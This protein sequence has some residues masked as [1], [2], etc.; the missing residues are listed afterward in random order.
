MAD[1]VAVRAGPARGR[2]AAGRAAW[3]RCPPIPSTCSRCWRR[4]ATCRLTHR[5]SPTRRADSPAERPRL[6]EGP[7][8]QVLAG[9]VGQPPALDR[10]ARCSHFGRPCRWAALRLD[11]RMESWLPADTIRRAGL[12]PR[13]GQ[14]PPRADAGARRVARAAGPGWSTP[15]HGTMPRACLR[16]SRGCW[17]GW[18]RPPGDPERAMLGLRGFD[19]MTAVWRGRAVAGRRAAGSGS[20]SAPSPAAPPGADDGAGPGGRDPAPLR[21]DPRFPRRLHA[22]LRRRRPAQED[23]RARTDGNPEARAH[24][25]DLHEPRAEGVRVRRR[26]ALLLRARPTSRSTWPRSRPATRRRRRRCSWPAR[27]TSRATS[28][29]RRPRPA[30][31]PAGSAAIKLT[32]VKPEREYETLV[33]VVDRATP[34]MADARDRRPPGRHVDVCLHQP[35]RER[36]ASRIASSSSRFP[37]ASM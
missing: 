32:P 29:R 16:R 12:R 8:Y 5:S 13:R 31:A 19:P 18:R 6:A 10:G 20:R 3:R 24:A 34:A 17:R 30:G 37:A 36:R 9:R 25:L 35:S 4:T 21:T 11:V 1:S 26:E 22:H 14:P 27:A 15:R 23:G 28:R 2:A 7:S 33:L